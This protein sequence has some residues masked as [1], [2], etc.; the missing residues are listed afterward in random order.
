[1][2]KMKKRLALILMTALVFT[3][4]SFIGAFAENGNSEAEPVVTEQTTDETLNMAE[5]EASTIAA[6][7]LKALASFQS[8]KLTWQENP[9]VEGYNVYANKSGK[10]LKLIKENL[11]ADKTSYTVKKIGSNALDPFTTYDFKVVPLKNGAEVKDAS[12][13]AS[14]RPVRPITYKIRI[15][16]GTTLKSHGTDKDYTGKKGSKSYTVRTGQWIEAQGYGAGGKYIIHRKGYIFY[17]NL[18]RAGAKEALYAKEF[19]YTPEEAEIFVNSKGVSSRTGYMVWV[20]TYTQHVFLFK[21]K[22]GSWKCV[23]DWECSTGRAGAPT[24]TGNTGMKSVWKK[25]PKRHNIPYWTCFSEINAL[26]GKKS[27]WKMGKPASNGCVRNPIP[28][29]KIIYEKVKKNARVY[30]Y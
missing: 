18:T 19:N 27:G 12:G 13:V 9:D 3:S 30:V 2:K 8:V 6:V 29:A 16:A 22:K 23:D 20:S 26:H 21:G 10:S 4:F 15:K 17:C 7:K 1:M 25:I 5:G 11:G 14:K 24:P 28:K